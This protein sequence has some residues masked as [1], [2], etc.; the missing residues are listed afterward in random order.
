MASPAKRG[1][2]MKRIYPFKDLRLKAFFFAPWTEYE[3]VSSRMKRLNHTTDIR[4]QLR[5][6]YDLKPCQWEIRRVA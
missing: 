4:C 2:R 5:P 3:R 1:E 6:R